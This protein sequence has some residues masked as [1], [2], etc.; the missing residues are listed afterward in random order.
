MTEW[1]IPTPPELEAVLV[2]D[3]HEFYVGP[4][5]DR[6]IIVALALWPDSVSLFSLTAVGT[7]MPT[8]GGAFTMFGLVDDAGSRYPFLAGGSGGMGGGMPQEATST[9]KRPDGR[10]PLALT[11]T[12]ETLVNGEV[13]GREDLVTITVPE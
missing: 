7:A 5:R 8:P 2:P 6:H 1:S 10:R 13:V 9:F 11:L 3:T 12:A 4:N